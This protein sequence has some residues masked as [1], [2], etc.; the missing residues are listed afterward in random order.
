MT[1]ADPRLA[2]AHAVLDRV[3]A[4]GADAI[5]R[6][7]LSLLVRRGDV[8]ARVRPRTEEPVAAREVEVAEALAEVQVP[9]V[10]LTGGGQ[11][12]IEGGCVV[13]TWRWVDAVGDASPSDQGGLARLL[14]E[15]TVGTVAFDVARFE[16]LVAIRNAVAHL[17]I[18]DPDAD[19]VRA[20]AQ[21]LVAPWAQIADHDPAGTAIVHGDLHGD[22]VVRT[23]AGP[24]LT[25]LELAGAGPPS[26]D[27][28][29]TVVAVERYGAPPSILDEFVEAQALDPRSWPGL[30]TC[31][32]IYELWTTA[33]AVGVR[34]RSP[35]LAAEAATRIRC[36]RDGSC[37]PWRLL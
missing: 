25:D 29:P 23:A 13:T 12:W 34:H 21:E 6:D 11:P 3:G 36:L 30:R 10:A 5:I 37:E 22:N 1:P 17:P 15:R 18:G 27:T 4:S 14:R 9:C 24:V 20:R 8:L 28:A 31:V 26:Y 35:E 7:G 16:P 33:W 19:F 2:A 32:A